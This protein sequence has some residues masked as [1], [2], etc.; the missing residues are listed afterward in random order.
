MDDQS[1][2][3]I[4]FVFLIVLPLLWKPSRKAIGLMNII[5]GAIISLT[6]V[7]II[8]GMPLILFGGILL[9]I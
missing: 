9:F 6:G 1:S 4:G 2:L 8:I 7:G 5:I 3:V